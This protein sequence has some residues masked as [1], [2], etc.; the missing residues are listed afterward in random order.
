MNRSF[1]QQCSPCDD[2]N[3][4]GPYN[5]LCMFEPD[6]PKPA[7]PFPI[8]EW[9][10]FVPPQFLAATFT[11]MMQ[12]RGVFDVFVHPNSGCEIYDHRDW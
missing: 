10:V 5:F 3:T 1:L 2:S 9:A 11:W 4:T 6:L 8:S 7:G 12:H